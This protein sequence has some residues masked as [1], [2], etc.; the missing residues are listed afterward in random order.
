MTQ[1]LYIMFELAI[2]LF[3]SILCVW[4][5]L[6]F[7]RAGLKSAKWAIPATLLLFGVTLI[8]DYLLADYFTVISLVLILISVAFSL[9]VSRK[10]PFRAIM[11]GCIFASDK[12]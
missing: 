9:S 5:I 3:D 10:H 2:S 6:R 11:A 1:A 7:H 4:F 12:R 8:G